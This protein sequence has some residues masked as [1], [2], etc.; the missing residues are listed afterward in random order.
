M[1]LTTLIDEMQPLLHDDT[2]LWGRPELLRA[3]Q[4]GYRDMLARSHAVVRPFQLEIPGRIAYSLT[5]EWEKQLALG[6]AL[7][8]TVAVR[9]SRTL[10]AT[11]LWE[12]EAIEGIEP[13]NSLD[14]TSQPWER[15]Y[16]DEVDARFRFVLPHSNERTLKVYWDNQRLAHTS[17]RE[18]DLFETQW[19]RYIGRPLAWL[20][21]SDA[22]GIFDIFEIQTVYTQAYDLRDADSGT[23][24]SFA[25]DDA[26]LYE[27]R[28]AVQAWD[29]A[30]TGS[31]D[32][33]FVDGLGLRI[34]SYAT[35]TDSDSFGIYSWESDTSTASDEDRPLIATGA[36]EASGLVDD[37]QLG[38]GLLRR[39]ES[40]ERQYLAASYDS[41]DDLRGVARR[42]AS[43]DNALTV[44]QA[45]VPARNLTEDDEPGLLP[46][47]FAKY[48]KFYALSKAFGRAGEGYRP[49]LA[50]HFAALYELGVSLLTMLGTPSVLDRV[51]VRDQAQDAGIQAPARVR[52]PSTFQRVDW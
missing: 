8:F 4:D 41:G 35:A 46:P 49:D 9:A 12:S 15:A 18:L 30:Y 22:T 25:S 11:Y 38:V 44:W 31:A 37:L 42:F 10:Q 45:I 14:A 47:Q 20:A 40:S 32:H 13:S 17:T 26:R 2:A 33:G 34:A 50:Q 5:Q 48:I 39:I 6:Q 52:L 51:Y 3:L 28:S 1:K 23:P 16:S 19:W 27:V 43:G 7:V 24:R 36:L 21:D 29:W